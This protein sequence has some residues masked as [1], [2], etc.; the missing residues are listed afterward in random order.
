MVPMVGTAD[1]GARRS[2]TAMKYHPAGGRGVALQV[3]HDRYRPGAVPTSSPPPTSAS[4]L[5]CQIETAEGVENAEA[6]AAIDGVDC[7]WVGHFDLSVSLGIPGQFDH[8]DFTR[9]DRRGPIAA[10]RKHKK[11][12]GRLVPDGRA[13]ASSSTATASISSAIPATSGCCTTRLREAIDE[14]ARR[15]CK[16]RK[17]EGS[18]EAP[19]PTTFRVALSGD[20]RKADGSPTYP[21]FDL[22]PAAPTARRRD[23]VS[24]SR[25]IRS[26]PTSSRISTR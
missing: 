24:R 2:S 26:G 4:T 9:G 1:G 11:A 22:A 25:P 10:C 6:M 13:R 8:P 5:F 14:A 18:K 23:G 17:R 12:L 20:F 16:A 21:D 3:A 19:W 7:L 15:A